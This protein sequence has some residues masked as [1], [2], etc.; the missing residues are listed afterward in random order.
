MYY[1]GYLRF[2]PSLGYVKKTANHI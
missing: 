2:K 1:I